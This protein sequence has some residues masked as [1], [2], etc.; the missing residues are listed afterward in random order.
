MRRPALSALAK[1][2]LT[3]TLYAALAMVPVPDAVTLRTA[4]E[5]ITRETPLIIILTPTRMPIAQT[6]LDGHWM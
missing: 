3:S 4:S 2:F 6:E 5:S 1:R